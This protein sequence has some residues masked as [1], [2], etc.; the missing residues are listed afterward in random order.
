M[1]RSILL[2][3]ALIFA[4]L[5]GSAHAGT[6]VAPVQFTNDAGSGISTTN[7][8]THLL[9]FIADGSPATI[10]GV[11]FTAAGTSGGNFTSSNL[12]GTIP[13]GL[14]DTYNAITPTTDGSHKL[15]SDFYYLAAG[16]GTETITLT[17]LTPG[18]HYLARDYYRAWDNTT[19]RTN[20]VTFNDGSGPQTIS[21]NQNGDLTHANYVGFDYIAPVSGQ[22]V[23]SIT[24]TNGD[25]ASWHQYGLS[26]QFITPEPSSIVLAGLAAVGLAGYSLK[27]R[28][29]RNA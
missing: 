15:L 29:R 18:A 28:R 19:N 27:R 5:A 6:I 3:A 8:Y 1:K 7:T 17:G 24:V 4:L 21:I 11:T 10:N 9:D 20:D 16:T 23:L 2:S 25:A 22:L 14:N 26:N 12:T 13:E